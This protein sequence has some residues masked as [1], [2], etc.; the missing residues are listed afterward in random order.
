MDTGIYYADHQ[1]NHSFKLVGKL[2]FDKSPPLFEI[3]EQLKDKSKLKHLV[4]DLK[5]A[6]SLDSTMFGAICGLGVLFL[7]KGAGKPI[8][9]CKKND[10]QKMIQTLG[11]DQIFDLKETT[12][13]VPG[14][15]KLDTYSG[16][17]ESEI[18]VLRAHEA[19]MY[20]SDENKKEFSNLVEM[21]KR[22]AQN[23]E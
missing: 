12:V 3:L 22:K 11:L 8:L 5:E 1:E 16:K 4:I 14:F 20:L 13:E 9:V 18:G 6:N 21:L 7:K 19:L 2:R 15:I 23:D 10:I 17:K